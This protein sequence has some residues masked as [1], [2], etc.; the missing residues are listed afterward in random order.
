MMVAAISSA[1]TV[2]AGLI[3]AVAVTIALAVAGPLL[4]RSH[5]EVAPVDQERVRLTEDLDRSLTAVGEIADDHALGNLSD[6]DLAELDQAERERAV[7]LMRRLE[8]NE[9]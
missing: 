5:E 8:P 1:T 3:A 9:S 7:R 4:N 2:A 6:A